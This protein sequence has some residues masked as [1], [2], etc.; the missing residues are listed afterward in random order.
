M[1]SLI[2]KRPK[3]FKK[4]KC[5]SIGKVTCDLPLLQ[6]SRYESSCSYYTLSIKR[7]NSVNNQKKDFTDP[8]VCKHGIAL[9]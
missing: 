1:N 6:A 2:S 5:S 8:S 9:N 7:L 4:D 3:F